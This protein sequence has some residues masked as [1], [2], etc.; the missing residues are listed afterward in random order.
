MAYWQNGKLYMHCTTQ[1]TIRTV[2]AV[3]RWVGINANDVVIISEYTGGGFGSKGSS[4]VFTVVPALLSRKANAPVMMRITR[5]EEQFI[6][7]A[8][9]ALHSRVKVGFRKDGRITALDGLVIVDN[10]PY[11]V[12][13]DGRAARSAHRAG[14]RAIRS[15]R[16]FWPRPHAG[17][18]SI[19][20]RSI[21]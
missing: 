15:W 8:R 13:G 16:R 12:V 4:S 14:C 1:S 3:A 11:D 6:G 21:A 7:R 10:G 2:N 17:S 9:P 18:G 20:S 5:E 19:N